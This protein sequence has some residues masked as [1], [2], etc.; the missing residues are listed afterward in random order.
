MQLWGLASPKLSVEHFISLNAGAAIL[1]LRQ[2][3]FLREALVLVKAL[4]L[5][6]WGPPRLSRENFLYLKSDAGRC[7]PHLQNT[8]TA[9]P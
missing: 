7:E 8:F 2:D 6:G 9:T 1:V 5:I 3:F 4:Q